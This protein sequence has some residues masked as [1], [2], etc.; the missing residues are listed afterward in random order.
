MPDETGTNGTLRVAAVADIHHANSSDGSLQPLLA[1]IAR[2]ADVLLLCGDL[3]HHGQP[4]EAAALVRETSRAHLPILAVLGNHDFHSGAQDE[5]K[6]TI[7]DG[8]IKVLDGDIA[9]V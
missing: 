1:A 8:G 6:R 9:E 3:T 2:R 7:Q 4:E 5:I